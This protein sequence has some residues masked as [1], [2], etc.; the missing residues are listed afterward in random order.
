MEELRRYSVE[1]QLMYMQ[2]NVY[3]EIALIV[4]TSNIKYA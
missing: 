2:L 3:I 4:S 1:L